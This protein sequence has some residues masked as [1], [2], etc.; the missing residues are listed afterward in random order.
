LE[1]IRLPDGT[2]MHIKRSRPPRR[3]CAFCD[4]WSTKLCDFKIPRDGIG[5]IR[6]RTCDKPLC[7]FCAVSVGADIDHC[8]DHPAA[9]GAQMKLD[10]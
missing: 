9:A 5:R 3:R 7:G 8:P 1:W 4:R 6:E 2:V 10:L